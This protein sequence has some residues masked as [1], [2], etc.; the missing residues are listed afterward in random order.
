MGHICMSSLKRIIVVKQGGIGDVILATPVLAELKRI[1]P[2]SY[3]TLMLFKN[4]IDIVNGLPFIDKLFTYDKKKDSV[5]KLWK[6]MHGNDIAIFLDLT[7]R[8]AMVAAL[9]GVPVRIGIEHKRKFWLTKKIKWQEYMDH[10]YEAYVMG[11][12]VNEGLGLNIP[13]SHLNKT[14]IAAASDDERK[15]L[16]AKLQSIGHIGENER[17]IVCSPITAYFLKDWPLERWN[18][19]FQ[20][21]YHNYHLKTVIFGRGKLE[22]NW[23]KDCTVNLWNMLNLRQVGEL[24]KKAT[25]LVNCDSMP[26]HIA[27]ATGTPT[28]VLDGYSE[29]K[30]WAP[31]KNCK[32]VQSKLSCAPCDGYHGTT[33]TDPQCMKQMT[34]DEVYTACQ[35][36]LDDILA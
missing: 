5:W 22:Y 33:C 23:D 28:V 25:L 36:V 6:E 2:D 15:D 8:P 7:Y 24:I 34:V 12:V 13:H 27:A 30:R 16:Q 11:D 21:I 14:Y 26:L 4:A 32:V 17:Y 31:R 19:L 10:T 29:P 9:A 3:I 1:Y 18:E 20:R 35:E